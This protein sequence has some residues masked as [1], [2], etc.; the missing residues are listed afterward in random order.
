MNKD[1][2][3]VLGVAKDA[4]QDDI[5][6]AYRALVKKFHPDL[7]PGNAEAEERFKEIGSAYEIV[8]DEDKRA[9][10]DRGDIDASGAE[11]PEQPFYREYADTGGTH[12]YYSS[13]GFDDFVDVSD[14]FSDLFGKRTSYGG[15]ARTPRGRDVQYTLDVGFLEAVNGGQKRI[16]L[17]DGRSLDV[18]IPAGVKDGQTIRL[19]GQGMAGAG[20]SDAGD[21]LVRLHVHG[22]PVFSREGDDILIE[23]PIS[24]DEAVLGAKIEVPTIGGRV[25][26]TVPKGSS[27]GRTLRL[28][29]RGVKRAGSQEKGDQLIRLQIALPEQIDEDLVEAMQKWR[30]TYPYDPREKLWGQV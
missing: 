25:S 19:R 18:K 26:V 5:R 16:T 9:R 17:P 24:L 2:Y 13:E 4:S 21:A 1:P 6:K 11:R 22:H 3:S 20:G 10:F 28:K 8:G 23:V 29:G 30:E 15:E 14:L 12:R 7:N 27:S